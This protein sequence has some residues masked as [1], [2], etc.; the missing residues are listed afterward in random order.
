MKTIYQSLLETVPGL[1]MHNHYSDLYVPV[2]E[3]T[4]RVIRAYVDDKNTNMD[5]MPKT[6][7]SQIEGE[8]LMYDIPLSYDPYWRSGE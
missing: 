5:T 7:K 3:E 2:N 6:F 4:M 8:G 1:V